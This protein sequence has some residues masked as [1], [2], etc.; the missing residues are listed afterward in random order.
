MSKLAVGEFFYHKHWLNPYSEQA[1]LCKITRIT[2]DRVYYRGCYGERPD[3][4]EILGGSMYL[5]RAKFV[6]TYEGEAHA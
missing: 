5:D 6:A 1:L 3:G 2:R 4:S